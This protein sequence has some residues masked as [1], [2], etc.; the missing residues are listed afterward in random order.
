MEVSVLWR[1]A[2]CIVWNLVSFEPSRLSV[3]EKCQHFR[4]VRKERFD[5]AF[6]VSG[7]VSVVPT[8]IIG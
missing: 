8:D 5:C 4:A 3:A 1:L 7:H 2:F 6:L